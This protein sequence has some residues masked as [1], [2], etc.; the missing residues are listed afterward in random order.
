MLRATVAE[1]AVF[2]R[3]SV[4]TTTPVSGDVAGTVFAGTEGG[5][6]AR[7][8]VIG[9]TTVTLCRTTVAKGTS[10]AD[11]AVDASATTVG[12]DLAGG[13]VASAELGLTSSIAVLSLAA[14]PAAFGTT[15]SK[16][17]ALAILP[18]EASATAVSRDGTGIGVA[19]AESSLTSCAAVLVCSAVTFCRTATSKRASLAGLAVLAATITIGGD[20]SFSTALAEPRLTTSSSTEIIAFAT[21]AVGRTAVSVRAT[22]AGLSILAARAVDGHI[23]SVGE[24]AVAEA[25]LASSSAVSLLG[26]AAPSS[27]GAAVAEARAWTNHAAV[28][29]AALAVGRDVRWRTACSKV[30]ETVAAAVGGRITA[31]AL[32]RAAVSKGASAADE[33]VCAAAGTVG[34]YTSRA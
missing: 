21:V 30:G 26:I 16:G 1:R 25:G 6:A 7:I 17:A 29:W 23:S 13:A 28:R 19:G 4:L 20:T 22:L 5:L 10:F 18:I 8:T 12:G 33:L 14:A 9:V 32:E 11:L 2:A 27:A 15:V 31:P 34:R 3:L 24:G